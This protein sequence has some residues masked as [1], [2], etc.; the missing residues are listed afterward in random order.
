MLAAEAVTRSVDL[1]QATIVEEEQEEKEKAE[2][3]AQAASSMAGACT[4]LC[5]CLLLDAGPISAMCAVCSNAAMR[6][7]QT[8]ADDGGIICLSMWLHPTADVH[9]EGTGA[10]DGCAHAGETQVVPQAMQLAA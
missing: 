6:C 3:A 9:D 10:D 8:P 2:A 5:A 7:M 1:W 4:P